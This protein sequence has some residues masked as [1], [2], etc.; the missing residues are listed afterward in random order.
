MQ[1]LQT[2]GI[3]L[4]LARFLILEE[5]WL[6]TRNPHLRHSDVTRSDYDR[7]RLGYVCNPRSLSRERRRYVSLPLPLY[8]GDRL[9]SGL[10]PQRLT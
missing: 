6:S 3:S 2:H 8:R 9:S 5:D 7:E 1:I 4:P 10:A